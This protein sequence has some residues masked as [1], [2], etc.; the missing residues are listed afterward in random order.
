MTDDLG[1]SWFDLDGRIAASVARH[2]AA[3]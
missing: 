1:Y 2:L 3:A